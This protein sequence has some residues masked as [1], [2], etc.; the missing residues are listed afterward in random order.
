MPNKKKGNS[1]IFKY[2]KELIKIKTKNSTIKTIYT[3]NNNLYF[4]TFLFKF[5]IIPFYLI[6][7][8]HKFYTLVMPEEGYA[9]LRIFSFSR[10][11]I[12][13]VHDYRKIF[14]N[15]NLIKFKEKVKQIYIDINFL[16]SKK[17]N[18]IIVPSNFTKKLVSKHLFINSDKICVIP[19]IINFYNKKPKY[20]K[21]FKTLKNLKKSSQIVLTITSNE[22]RKN[23]NQLYLIARECNK[24]NFIIVGNLNDKLNLKNVFY[25]KNL[26]DENLIY[27][28]RMSNIYLDVSLFEGFGRSL[29]EAQFFKLKVVCLKTKINQEILKNSA[30]LIGINSKASEICKLL[31]KRDSKKLKT[32]YYDNAKKFFSS[33]IHK[34][35][36]KNINE[37]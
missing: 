28:F 16:F 13:I 19:N 18:K 34:N 8:S 22:T 4:F 15:N 10:K 25:F 3:G 9:F 24:T 36:K 12:L 26:S 31:N 37:I 11:N 29:I 5:L 30:N 1:G 23:L 2:N 21:K 14:S 17:F 6:F 7:N 20:D 35:Y 27:L 33:T 32:K